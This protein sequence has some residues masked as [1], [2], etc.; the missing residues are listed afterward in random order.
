[1]LT[2]SPAALPLLLN[3][4]GMRFNTFAGATV[5]DQWQQYL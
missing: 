1:V 3:P 5:C 4:D 2:L